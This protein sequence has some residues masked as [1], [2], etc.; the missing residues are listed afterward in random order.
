MRTQQDR[1]RATVRSISLGT[2]WRALRYPFLLGAMVYIPRIMTAP[3]YG[4]F[5]VFLS[6]YM[7]CESFTGLGNVQVFGR[8]LPVY[9]E[10]D[11]DGRRRLLHSMLFYGVLV[12]LAVVI[13][14]TAGLTWRRPV[15]FNASWT[16]ALALV[17]LLGKVQ[18]TLF[19]Y[20][21]GSNQIG[22]FSSRDLI[23]SF[24]RFVVVL[25]LFLAFGLYGAIWAFVINEAILVVISAW[26]TRKVLFARVRL[27]PWHAISPYILFGLAF[28]VPT[29]LV[30]MLQRSG[31]LLIDAYTGLAEEIGYFDLANQFLLLTVSFLGILLATLLP[32][33][34]QFQI[35]GEH[36][37]AETW[38]RHAVVFC[39]AMA[40]VALYLL[41]FLGPHVIP[42]VGKSFDVGRVYGNALLLGI[43]AFPL[44]L[45][46]V[47]S[48]W[49]VLQRDARGYITIS[50]VS[51]VLMIV[52]SHF[53]I[54]RY[55]SFGASAAS[56]VAY[57]VFAALF[58]FRYWSPMRTMLISLLR[59]LACAILP[60]TARYFTHSVGTSIVG[61]LLSLA[62]FVVL[63]LL[64]RTVCISDLKQ[65]LA[66]LRDVKSLGATEP[67]AAQ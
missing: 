31:G 51:A 49:A 4:R 16:I 36:E 5:A 34:T 19:A 56:L 14:A 57:I 58:C 50:A 59:V 33:L 8:F 23:R 42:V 21:Y 55:A 26:W 17:L 38:M 9:A 44:L 53:W 65:Y 37:R 52:L 25:S 47:G 18:G 15:S 48:N 20:L 32:S 7:L 13:V 10:D 64:T 28:Y 61:F 46:H 24:S 62:S 35:E 2:V 66:S 11:E 29:V 3:V 40:V 67:P 43:A 27:L 60:V 22:R 63:L 54:P 39:T 30:G 6:V 12:T 1:D 41:C 45:V